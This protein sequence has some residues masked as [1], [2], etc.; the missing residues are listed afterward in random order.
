VVVLLLQKYIIFLHYKKTIDKKEKI[1]MSWMSIVKENYF[2][3]EY[4]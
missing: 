3:V 1:I 2:Y 4:G